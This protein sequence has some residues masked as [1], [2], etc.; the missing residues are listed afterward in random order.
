MD[1]GRPSA[2]THDGCEPVQHFRSA[3]FSAW[4]DTV[5]TELCKRKVFLE[6]FGFLTTLGKERQHVLRTTPS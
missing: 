5:A 6:K 1:P 2:F 3:I 4:Q